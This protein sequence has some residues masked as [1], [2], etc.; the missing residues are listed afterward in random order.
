[1]GAVVKGA[2]CSALLCLSLLAG[3]GS[4]QQQ[5]VTVPSPSASANLPTDSAATPTATT[6]TAASTS[7]TYPLVHWTSGPW[8]FTVQLAS[9]TMSPEGFPGS[10]SAPPGYEKLMVRVN[11][12]SLTSGR[13]AVTPTD[14]EVQIECSGPNSASWNS[15][16]PASTS[17]P[18]VAGWDEGEDAP[19]STGANIAMGYNEPHQWDAEW[20]VPENTKPEVVSC[21]IVSEPFAGRERRLALTS[22]K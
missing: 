12:T 13:T 1:M 9:I 3:C 19:D 4:G 14:S 11:I 6:T 16:G 5:T 22:P 18:I 10:G 2:G 8:P 15:G 17:V 20:E 7:S 21:T